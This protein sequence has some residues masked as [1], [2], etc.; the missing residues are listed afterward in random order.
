MDDDLVDHDLSTERGRERN[1]LHRGRRGQHI[2]PDGA[3][4]QQLGHERPKPEGPLLDFGRLV[5]LDGRN[6]YFQ[7]IVLVGFGER[8]IRKTAR[9]LVSFG[10][11]QFATI[12]AWH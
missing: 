11:Q 1:E 2:P 9:C 12:G 8:C 7:Q 5:F 6:P 10:D 4:P 3:M